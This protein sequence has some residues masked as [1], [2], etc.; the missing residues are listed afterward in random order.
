MLHQVVF[1]PVGSPISPPP[2]TRAQ[3][4]AHTHSPI[5]H[6]PEHPPLWSPQVS[7]RTRPEAEPTGRPGI[8]ALEKRGPST[9]TRS[10]H[11]HGHRDC[12]SGCA[13]L[14]FTD[15][16]CCWCSGSRWP[17]PRLPRSCALLAPG[18]RAP[19]A[20]SARPR[21][22]ARFIP[23]TWPPAWTR[24]LAAPGRGCRERPG[25][26]RADKCGE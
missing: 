13:R 8:S 9:H 7:T 14:L 5:S 25:P 18:S 22:P 19:P 16:G 3:I 21:R 10:P 17:P 11:R 2:P 4:H 26:S 12:G 15:T 23:A 1:E 24:P 6:H 20:A